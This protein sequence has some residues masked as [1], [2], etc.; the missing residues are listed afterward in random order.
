MIAESIKAARTSAGMTQT[1]LATEIGVSQA[2]LSTLES[3]KKDPFTR[4][5]ALLQLLADATG[6]TRSRLIG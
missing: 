6:T 3:G 2:Y 4:P 1:E 5:L